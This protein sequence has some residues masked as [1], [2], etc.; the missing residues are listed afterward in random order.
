[1]KILHIHVP[2]NGGTFVARNFG[3]NFGPKETYI[4]D[5]E[6]QVLDSFVENADEITTNFRYVGG[7]IPFRFARQFARKFD[8]IVACYREPWSRCLSFYRYVTMR[9]PKW[10]HLRAQ[11]GASDLLLMKEFVKE[12][13]CQNPSTRNNQCGYLG[14]VNLPVSALEA[15]DTYNIKM[16]PFT[17]IE[18]DLQK[19]MSGHGLKYY[20]DALKN[21]SE[22]E[23][24]GLSPGMRAKWFSGDFELISALDA[25]RTA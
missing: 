20:P 18:S 8:L 5:A 15:I 9:E 11:G 14:E 7:H 16:I 24:K 22:G 19:L 23:G 13:F 2:K 17:N 25:R 21:A 10:S 3:R 4:V 12:Y 6:T 1:M